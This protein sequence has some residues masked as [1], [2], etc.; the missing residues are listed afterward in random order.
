[1]YYYTLN[2]DA[3]AENL[4]RLGHIVRGA[5]PLL[6]EYIDISEE[7]S[8]SQENENIYV[9][10]SDVSSVGEESIDTAEAEYPESSIYLTFSFTDSALNKLHALFEKKKQGIILVQIRRV[11]SLFYTKKNI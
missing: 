8:S 1:M 11:L 7:F 10:P 2:I 9:I 4:T 3:T 6:Q 5:I